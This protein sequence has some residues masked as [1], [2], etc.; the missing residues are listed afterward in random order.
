MNR[1]LSTVEINR[2]ILISTGPAVVGNL[3]GSES[4][5]EIT[6]LGSPVNFLSRLDDSTKLPNLAAELE[7]GDIIVCE[8]T[9]NILEGL[10]LKTPL[11]RLQLAC[12]GIEIRDFP[13]TKNIFIAK[14]NDGLSNELLQ[15]SV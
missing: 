15:L 10:G 12:L 13:E 3:G 5:V 4:A 11:R 14:P 1:T 8:R 6:A 7:P 2:Y 9:A